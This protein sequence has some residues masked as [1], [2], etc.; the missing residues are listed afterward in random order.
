M[1]AGGRYDGLVEVMGGKATPAIGFAMG[2]ERL[3]ELQSGQGSEAAAHAP[4][5]YVVATR[6]ELDP[7]AVA[8]AEQLREQ[9][10]TWQ[11]LGHITG[12]SLKARMKKADRSGARLALIIGDEEQANNSVTVKSLRT[13]A[14]Q[15]SC[16]SN[17]L[18]TKLEGL[19]FD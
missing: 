13:D 12:G 3:L 15:L 8:L 1:C 10:P 18:I 17:Q 5:L 2:L 4:E 11:T 14:E 7:L 16:P 19:L 6:P 9:R